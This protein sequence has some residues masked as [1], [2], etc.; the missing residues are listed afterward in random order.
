MVTPLY[1]LGYC[2]I[3]PMGII[4]PDMPAS[5][6]PI[7]QGPALSQEPDYRTY[8]SPMQLRRMTKPIRMGVYAAIDCLSHSKNRPEIAGIHVGTAYG[9]LEDSESF[10]KQIVSQN[11]A[12][13]SPTAFIQS[14]HNTVAGQIAL[15]LQINAHNMT[16]VHQ[17]HSFES[18]IID[19]RSQLAAHEDGKVLVGGVDECTDLGH[20]AIL[21]LAAPE[22]GHFVGEG[23]SFICAASKLLPNDKCFA[24]ISYHHFFRTNQEA[25]AWAEINFI[26]KDQLGHKGP[27]LLFMGTTSPYPD[28]ISSNERT[29]IIDYKRYCGD[30]PTSSA[31]GLCMAIDYLGAQGSFQ[32]CWLITRYMDYWGIWKIEKNPDIA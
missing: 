5:L 32:S 4:S 2:S 1:I 30:Y 18:A 20:E 8:L 29:T 6:R 23:A 16:F 12:M 26:L 7:G 22:K 3:G 24:R 9:M 14:T 28:W 27:E 10:L 21:R 31:A 15:A 25:E 13:L 17:G 11:E 19:A